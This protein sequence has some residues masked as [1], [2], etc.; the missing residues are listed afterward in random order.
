L[1]DVAVGKTGDRQLGDASLARGARVKS[2]EDEPPG[3][4][5]SG[6]QLGVCSLREGVCAA[7]VGEVERGPE[8]FAA[9]GPVS[10]TPERGAEVGQGSG[11]LKPSA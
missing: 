6:D 5:A 11:V 7:A 2:G 1:R 9:V 4:P 10:R 8:D 3:S